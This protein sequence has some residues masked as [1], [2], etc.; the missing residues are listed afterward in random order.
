MNQ[1]EENYG[2]EILSLIKITAG[3]KDKSKI[4][5]IFQLENI[6]SADPYDNDLYDRVIRLVIFL[7]TSAMPL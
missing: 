2:N 4:D 7:K 1:A 5:S 6:K 3:D